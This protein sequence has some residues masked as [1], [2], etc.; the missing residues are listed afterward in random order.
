METEIF[1]KN[2]GLIAIITGALVLA[3]M[4]AHDSYWKV[5]AEAANQTVSD[6]TPDYPTLYVAVDDWIDPHTFVFICQTI[7]VF[8][9]LGITLVCTW[10]NSNGIEAID[11]THKLLI[12]CNVANQFLVVFW[13]T[14]VGGL[15]NLMSRD[16]SCISIELLKSGTQ[17]ALQHI[18]FTVVASSLCNIREIIFK[19]IIDE[20][21]NFY[22]QP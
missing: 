5:V 13:L 15:I 18:C 21:L 8:T 6:C 4:T 22:R 9:N 14:Y 1:M 16:N 11:I 10:W 3:Q 20:V 2:R 19:M 12:I 7:T 17:D